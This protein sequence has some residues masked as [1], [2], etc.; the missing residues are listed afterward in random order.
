M[1]NDFLKTIIAI[2][3]F[4]KAIILEK[5]NILRD[6]GRITQDQYEDLSESLNQK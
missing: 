4:N 1:I 2:G 5:I 6:A 3:K